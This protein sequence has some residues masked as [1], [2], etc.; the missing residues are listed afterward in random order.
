MSI[1]KRSAV[2]FAIL[3]IL[4]LFSPEAP[5]SAEDNNQKIVPD[6][7]RIL[8]EQV[9]QFEK[10]FYS[11]CEM[12]TAQFEN[13][14]AVFESVIHSYLSL[15]SKYPENQ[16]NEIAFTYLEK[17]KSL[18]I[19]R[20]F[21]EATLSQSEREEYAPYFGRNYEQLQSRYEA[22]LR[23]EPQSEPGDE[24]S[25]DPEY[26]NIDTLNLPQDTKLNLSVYFS[27]Q[28]PITA[29]YLQ[30]SYLNDH[31]ALIDYWIHDNE[32]YVFIVTVDSFLTVN[33]IAPVSEIQSSAAHLISS[34]VK[35]QNLLRLEFNYSLAHQLY[36]LLFKP[37]EFHLEQYQVLL[38]IPDDK[39]AGFPFEALVADTTINKK[40][41]ENIYYHQF[42]RFTYLTNKFAFCYNASVASMLPG[43]AHRYA[44]QK[45]GRRLLTMS[46]P[47]FDEADPSVSQFKKAEIYLQ[48][49]HYSS[50][51]IK[52]VS[53]LLW[54]H[55]NLIKEEV[56][57]SQFKNIGNSY[58]WIYLALPGLLA[59]DNPMN[60]GILF[61]A[62]STQSSTWLSASE[63]SRSFLTADMLTVSMSN[64]CPQYKNENPG[65][66]T[67]PQAFLFSGVKSV[68]FSL[69]DINSISTSQFMS[70]FYWELKYKRQTNAQ[71]L[72]EAKIASM[73]DVIEVSGKQISK[74]HPYFWASFKLVG[75]PK[76]RPPST[77]KI[78]YWGVIIIVYLVVIGA[79]LFITRKTLPT[80]NN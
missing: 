18:K 31:E 79:A 23:D 14:T 52:R 59:N 32:I 9:L 6:S 27:L 68:V 43:Q 4:F 20:Q 44:P 8:Q 55:D 34:L 73:K 51:E 7:L 64:L 38:L 70:K 40:I 19:F 54:R 46:E 21:S 28:R 2:P 33:W 13:G 56:T 60:S 61:S 1:L 66:Y 47:I 74:A 78:P 45:L 50:D 11:H 77:T 49:S 57:K 58:R 29:K 71:A 5:C 75:N 24:N 26:S 72:Q 35:N 80:R 37:I 15:H 25:A 41:D 62:D 53:R 76:I 42:S 65:V 16:F 36:Q 67:L 39:L 12:D 3:V 10:D 69:W 17:L 30:H 22:Q 48:P 63:I